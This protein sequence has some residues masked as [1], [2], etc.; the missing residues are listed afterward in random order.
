VI[1]NIGAGLFVWAI[2]P[3]IL[4]ITG[5]L[6]H[7][8]NHLVEASMALHPFYLDFQC[9]EVLRNADLPWSSF[10]FRNILKHQQLNYIWT[11]VHY[12]MVGGIYT[13]VGVF[14]MEWSI[15]QLKRREK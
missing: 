11:I 3:F 1:L 8:G 10:E 9:L 4:V 6:I 13:L 12:F 7:N 14:C 2:L 15:R 5:E